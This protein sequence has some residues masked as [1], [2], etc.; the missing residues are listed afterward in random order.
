MKKSNKSDYINDVNIIRHGN[1][2]FKKKLIYLE[3]N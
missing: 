3:K 1:P 2:H